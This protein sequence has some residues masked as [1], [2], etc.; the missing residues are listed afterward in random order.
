M[1]KEIQ[2]HLDA[3]EKTDAVRILY[4]CESGSR[5]W[6][7]PST[8]SD[9]DVRFIYLRPRDWY[10]SIDLE[11]K[12]DVIERPI[13]GQL[14][15]SGWDLR[16][17]LHLLARSNPP[18]IE[19]LGSPIVYVERDRF[20]A[21]MRALATRHYSPISCMYH[22]L[23]T[24]QRTYQDHLTGPRVSVKKYFYAL[25]PLL[26]VRWLDRDLGI[27]PTEFRVLVAQV[28]DEPAL[29]EEIEHLVQ[30]KS[31]GKEKDLVPHIAPISSF[32]EHELARYRDRRFEREYRRLE[33]PVDEY[34]RVFRAAL[35]A[36]W[37]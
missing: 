30:A 34:D 37:D 13:D 24:A 32:I 33:V 6:G 21:A 28:V 35:E 11:Y 15:I 31:L 2:N 23:R 8:D 17:A 3:V 18:L 22:Y 5:A 19:W 20:A 27:V 1:R 4:A 16:K 14:D 7:F 9:Y 25:R 12:R 36:M 29:K 10:L 26:A